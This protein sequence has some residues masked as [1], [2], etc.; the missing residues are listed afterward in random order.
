MLP[1]FHI[2]IKWARDFCLILVIT[3]ILLAALE[4][5]LRLVSPELATPVS[6]PEPAYELHSDYLISLRPNITKQFTRL[7]INGGQT[8]EWK[9]NSDGYRGEETTASD[10]RVII[11]GDSNIQ[12]R[13]SELESTF[14]KQLEKQLSSNGKKSTSVTNAGVLGFG[15]DQSL[16]R[17][18]LEAT[19]L[20]PDLV[21]FHIF[22]D[23]DF[24][25]PVRNRLFDLKDNNLVPTN[26]AVTVDPQLEE[27][28]G[29]RKTLK[30]WRKSSAIRGA[31]KRFR[32]TR[33]QKD[34]AE[35]GN[36]S[37]PFDEQAATAE[38]IREKT[39]LAYKNYINGGTREVSHFEDYY[40]LDLAVN[41]EGESAI[42]KAALLEAILKEAKQ[43]ADNLGIEFL[44]VI[45]PSTVDL[46]KNWH[47]NAE[48]LSGRFP[49]YSK[50]RLTSSA[51][52]IC[53]RNDIPFVNLY[54][55]FA[56]NMPSQL[57]FIGDDHWNDEGQALAA[58]TVADFINNR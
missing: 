54:E 56:T 53:A 28:S 18:K 40:D 50:N 51:A 4:L 16:I 12:A 6:A 8:I 41:P 48:F 43:T 15:P 13:F 5:T 25:D 34:A 33:K 49:E 32:T 14:P 31:V 29:F 20:Q 47:L 37:Y 55:T 11:Y 45:Q 52:N 35:A 9:T 3:L 36:Y 30:S 39:E 44:V 17:F 27:Y 19:K 24:G 2:I 10:Y 23:N 21:I 22:A 57:Y 26:F 7:D 38:T 1:M 42:L 58:R 46:T